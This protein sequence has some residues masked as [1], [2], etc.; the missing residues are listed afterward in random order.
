[1]SI[2]MSLEGI[3]RCST[4][5]AYG[6][7]MK[8]LPLLSKTDIKGYKFGPWGGASRYKN[9]KYL[10]P[11]I[12]LAIKGEK[13]KKRRGTFSL[14]N[15]FVVEQQSSLLVARMFTPQ[16]WDHLQHINIFVLRVS[17]LTD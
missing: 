2:K 1:M 10:S 15:F 7:Y 8:G 11:G 4:V 3:D 5:D 17:V 12:Q 13:L 14:S 16:V 9:F 6:R